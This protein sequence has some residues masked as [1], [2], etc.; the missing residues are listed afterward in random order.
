MAVDLKK[1]L[2]LSEL[3][4][5]RSGAAVRKA[6]L[7]EGDLSASMEVGSI[8]AAEGIQGL[9]FPSVVGGDDN[10]IIYRPNCGRKA[11]ILQNEREVIEKATEIAAKHR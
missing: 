10:L 2:D 6:C 5:S 1:V 11:M 3:V 9:L 7:A 4:K 8:L